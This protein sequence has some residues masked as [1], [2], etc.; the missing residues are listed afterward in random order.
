MVHGWRMSQYV[1]WLPSRVRTDAGKGFA[2]RPLPPVSVAKGHRQGPSSRVASALFWLVIAGGCARLFV[3]FGGSTERPHSR[4]PVYGSDATSSSTPELSHVLVSGDPGRVG[5]MREPIRT[6]APITL[7][8]HD[9]FEE[10]HHGGLRVSWL[11]DQDC[12]ATVRMSIDGTEPRVFTPRKE[13]GGFSIDLPFDGEQK[14]GWY[15]LEGFGQTVLDSVPFARPAEG[16]AIHRGA[17]FLSTPPGLTISAPRFGPDRR[18]RVTWS[19]DFDGVL[20]SW[21]VSKQI[22]M[23]QDSTLEARDIE[24]GVHAWTQDLNSLDLGNEGRILVAPTNEGVLIAGSEACCRV[25]EEGET[26]GRLDQRGIT[27]LYP[28]SNGDWI[29]AGDDSHAFLQIWSSRPSL[30]DRRFGIDLE[31]R[32]V[33]MRVT[34]DRAWILTGSPA[35]AS[36]S[37]GIGREW[38]RL[39][40]RDAEEG[41]F[42]WSDSLPP[43]EDPLVME[44]LD[45]GRFVLLCPDRI[46]VV[47]PAAVPRA[48]VTSL[49]AGTDHLVGARLEKSGDFRLL[50]R[51]QNRGIIKGRIDSEGLTGVE[52]RILLPEEPGHLMSA[53]GLD[54]VGWKN[55][56]ELFDPGTDQRFGVSGLGQSLDAA[57]L[58]PR[59]IL[60]ILEGSS[61]N[62]TGATRMMALS[63]D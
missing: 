32:F 34:P 33:D 12:E 54:V 1:G 60:L 46:V 15:R 58:Q 38:L 62:Q 26:A 57:G 22:Y 53:G 13:P 49:P 51:G 50:A 8:V 18:V 6:A 48:T 20:T 56:I 17:R 11:C 14:T 25:T 55:G 7:R 45:D 43:G 28:G 10:I 44:A 41:G 59:R 31:G 19:L 47:D 36:P 29:L 9:L 63:V 27:G 23:I 39:T 5:P 4:F 35:V 42:M 30:E 2:P 21:C 24:S 61:G 52:H 37:G 40:V 3:L 16:R